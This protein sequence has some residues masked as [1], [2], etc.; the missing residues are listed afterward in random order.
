M[1]HFFKKLAVTK[2][3]MEGVSASL[4]ELIKQLRLWIHHKTVP[5]DSIKNN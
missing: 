5:N 2:K 3:R 4:I 1:K